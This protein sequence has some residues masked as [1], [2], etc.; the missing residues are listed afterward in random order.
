MSSFRRAVYSDIPLI[1]KFI[2][3]NLILQ[4]KIQFTSMKV[5]TIQIHNY[6]QLMLNM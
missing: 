6:G 2:H 3:E 4:K 1:Q 5:E